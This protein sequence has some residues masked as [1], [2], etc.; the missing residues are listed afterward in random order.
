MSPKDKDQLLKILMDKKIKETYMIPEYQD[1]SEALPLYE[2]LLSLSLQQDHFVRGIYLDGLLIGFINDVEINDKQIEL[3][4]VILPEYHNKGYMTTAL[5]LALD[6]LKQ[7]GYQTVT[8]G[9]FSEN[10][11]SGRVMEKA[12]M[13]MMDKEDIIRYHDQDHLCKYRQIKLK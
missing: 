11:A 1:I 7:K 9:Y 6:Q 3:G 2:R 4:Y 12:G 8:A 13:E 10:P 5:I